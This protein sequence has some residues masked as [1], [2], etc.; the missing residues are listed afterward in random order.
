GAFAGIFRL[1]DSEMPGGGTGCIGVGGGVGPVMLEKTS[2]RT[3][4]LFPDARMRDLEDGPGDTL[5][6]PRATLLLLPRRW[7][8][9]ATA[10][11]RVPL[12]APLPCPV[13]LLE[14]GAL[15]DTSEGTEGVRSICLEGSATV[16][17]VGAADFCWGVVVRLFEAA[18]FA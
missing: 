4:D 1:R 2:L 3:T 16:V 7:L 18:N 10:S 5:R 11:L 12:E 6:V 9:E 17:G 14:N 13:R 15:G 8:L